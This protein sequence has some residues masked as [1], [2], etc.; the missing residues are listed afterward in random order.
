M[1]YEVVEQIFNKYSILRRFEHLKL[2]A[3]FQILDKSEQAHCF[4][5]QPEEVEL[6]KDIR[7]SFPEFNGIEHILQ[8]ILQ[9][10]QEIFEL[11]GVKRSFDTQADVYINIYII[12]EP[13]EN[14]TIS[15]LLI[16]IKDV[17]NIIQD[18]QN[19]LKLTNAAS[20]LSMTLVAYKNYMDTVISSMADA[21]LVTSNSGKIKKVNLAALK[22]FDFQEEELINQ[23]ISLIFDDNFLLLRIINHYSK[24]NRDLQHFE[25]VCRKKT[26]EKVLIAFSCAVMQKKNEV[27][28]DIIYI[29]RDI[30]SRK[31]REQRNNAQYSITRILSESQNIKQAMPQILQAICQSLEWDVGELWTIS[32]YI[33][34][35]VPED[36]DHAVLRCVEIWSSRLVSVREFKAVTWQTTYHPSMGL[37]GQIWA[38]RSPLWIK[39]IS[40]YRDSQ[41]KQ[42]AIAAGL[43][44]AFGFP[45]LDDNKVLGVMTFFSR[46]VQPNDA[47]LLQMMVSVGS[48]IAQFMKRKQAEDNLLE[49]ESQYRDICENAND[50][51]V[52]VNPYGR[53]LYVNQAWC[54][55]L[56]YSEDAVE[57]IS[58]F[59]IIHPDFKEYYRQMFY[60]LMSGEE[61]EQVKVAFIAKNGQTVFLEGNVNCKFAN[62]RPVAMRG[63]FR[64]IT[65]RVLLEEALQNQQAQTEQL[66]QVRIS[67]LTSNALRPHVYD[68]DADVI[69]MTVLCADIVGLGEVAAVGSAM[70]LVNLLSPIFATFDRLSTRYGLEKI[71]TINDAYVVI[72]GLPT[73]RKDHAHAIAQMALDM[74]TAIATFNIENQQNLKICIGIH[75]GIVTAAAT[76]L[77]DTIDIARCIEAQSLADTIQVTATAYEQIRHEFLFQKYDEIEISNQRKITTY[78][79]MGK[80]GS[81]Q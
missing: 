2:D 62:G 17:T 81:G 7:L 56:G 58:I 44:S 73:K 77:M 29:G 14:L 78:L 36:N 63:I 13:S 32:Q 49:S 39:D 12:A 68:A 71:K 79:L 75:T 65:Q 64:N 38:R 11:S 3:H 47:D 69:N 23:P 10:E 66:W 70:Q 57:Q 21:L 41:R 51:I 46:D 42:T 24:I 4:A 72:C 19:L 30:T 59:D 33:S 61:L 28:E 20:I 43:H 74:Q 48:Q 55:T 35:D 37:P 76:G 80:K 45:I 60:Q 22:L 50:L 67:P 8:S 34:T 54:R 18:K 26:G 1:K 52:S 53:F 15:K 9:G 16:L 31:R 27:L 25:V 40:D 6:G 5:S